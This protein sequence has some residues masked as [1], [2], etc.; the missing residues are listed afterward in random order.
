MNSIDEMI[1]YGQKKYT[2][3]FDGFDEF[4]MLDTDDSKLFNLELYKILGRE[5][6][7]DTMCSLD[8]PFVNCTEAQYPNF[9]SDY[10]NLIRDNGFFIYSANKDT[11]EVTLVTN[12]YKPVNSNI[13]IHLRG[14]NVQIKYVTPLNYKILEVGL[15][16]ALSD[17]NYVIYFKRIIYDAMEKNVSDVHFT[18]NQ[19]RHNSYDYYIKYRILN[20][21]VL[22][23]DFF[24]NKKLNDRLIVEVISNYTTAESADLETSYGVETSWVNIMRNGKVDLRITCSKTAGGYTMVIRIQQMNTLGKRIENLGFNTLVSRDLRDL[25]D[26]VTGLTLITG[27]PRTGKNTTM[28]AMI[29]EHIDDKIK[30]IEYSSPIETILPHEQLSYDSDVDT[31]LNFVKLAKKQDIDLAIL[32]ELPDKRLAHPVIDLVNSSIGVITTFHINR[33]WNVALKLKSYFGDDFIDLITQINGVVN[34]KMFVKLC[35][36]CTQEVYHRNFPKHILDVMDEYT[37]KSFKEARGCIRCHRTG[38]SSSVQPFAE[39]LIFTSE[40][41]ERLVMCSKPHEMER[42]LKKECYDKKVNMEVSVT[43][44]IKDGI[45]HPLDLDIL[46]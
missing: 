35:P 37:I 28:V 5:S 1:D 23:E 36:Y 17:V 2:A 44:A 43:D 31:L 12:Y 45:L 40:L 14:Y 16:E 15:D 38:R 18:N 27:A 10:F 39:S 22:Q 26:R 4:Q 24:I 46:R 41:K 9:L 13:I 29:N 30:R 3:V 19:N 33:L 42:I 6:I 8:L 11:R 7:L 20:N 25:S 21:Y 34:Q 32:N